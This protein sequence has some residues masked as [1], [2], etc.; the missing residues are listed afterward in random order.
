MRVL[1]EGQ[2]NV[3]VLVGDT[4]VVRLPKDEDGAEGVA[5][6]GRLLAELAGTLMI[7]VP[8]YE[9]TMPNP[10]GPGECAV[11]PVVPG[12]VLR[13]EEWHAR[14]LLEKDE[15]ATVIAEFI[16][17]VQRF[18]VDRAREFGIEEPDFRADFAAD[19]EL[20]RAQVIPL[21][22][23]ADGRELVRRW[24]G[25]LGRDGNFEYSPV[26]IHADVSLDHLLVTGDRITGVIDFGDAQ[27]GD[28][29]YDLCYLWPEAGPEFVRRV[30]N[31]RGLPFDERLTGKL[32]FWAVSD[33]AIDVLHAIEHDMPQFR[34]DRLRR[35]RDALAEF[36]HAGSV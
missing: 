22:S 36:D 20:V 5:R 6:E 3:A 27:I 33:A 14:G 12:E 15:T 18:S 9:F 16:D 25:Y 7:R 34:D 23:A 11:Y 28:P 35:L 2:E 29:D 19:L 30:Q 13:A 4:Y 31:C 21:L 17:G 24:E 1:G 8:R 32:N 10:L 26:L